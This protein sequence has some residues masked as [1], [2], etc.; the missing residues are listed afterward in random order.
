MKKTTLNITGMTCASCAKAV[1]R[2]GKKLSGVSESV[3]NF[4]TEELAVT[5]DEK[6]IKVQDIIAAINK[7]GYGAKEK[8]KDKSREEGKAKEQKNLVIRVIIS[9]VFTLPLLYISMGHMIGLPLPSFLLPDKKPILFAILQLILTVPVV[10]L[11]YKFY[12]IGFKSLF[13]LR[14]N[15]DSLIAVSTSSALIYGIFAII[16]IAKGDASYVHNL[17]FES[18]AVIITLV[19]L[20]KYLENKSKGRTSE[21]IKKLINLTPKTAVVIREGQETIVPF[22]DIKVGDILV[23][24]GGESL[25]VDGIVTEGYA[26]VDESMITGESMPVE[27]NIGDK[28][29]SASIISKGYIKYEAKKVGKDTTISQIIKLVEEAQGSKAP[30]SKL[31]DKISLYFVP[32]IMALAIISSLAWFISGESV[33]FAL[34]IF[35][36]VLVIACPCAL[37]LATPT[38]IMVGTGKGAE[39]GILIKNGEALETAHKIDTVVLDKTG[40][41]TE[42]NPKVTD[43]FAFNDYTNEQIIM[44]AASAEKGS[45]HPLGEAI[46]S[47]A[48]T[49]NIALSEVKNFNSETGF[50]ISAQILDKAVIIGNK[51]YMLKSGIALN[52]NEIVSEKLATEG[53]TPMYVAID[54]QLSGIVAVADV[55]KDNSKRAVE[56]LRKMNIDVVMLT[57]DNKETA[58]AIASSVGIDSTFAEVLPAEKA[59]KIKELK[60]SGKIVAMVGDGINDSP[61]LAMANVGIAIGS[62]TDIAI[63]SADIVLMKSDLL[64][65][66]TA[67]KLS[68]ST[69]KNI[70]ENL[71]WA[72]GY[73]IIGVPIAMGLLHL[74]NGPLLNPMIAGAAMSFSSVS[75][76]LNALRLTR[77]KKEH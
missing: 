10:V 52:D 37:G 20:G 30:I 55:V 60:D 11:G 49:Q 36:S 8:S 46:V 51:K 24:K 63:E 70:K 65:V 34:T 69:I 9:A 27:K 41:I 40:T 4:A 25:P 57:G 48:D 22:E 77:F 21:A 73:N 39:Y 19:S 1:E 62:G 38:A 56:L 68:K 23:V 42:G 47:Y 31:A 18:V 16:K 44:Y 33:T 14:P 67:I 17:Y 35:I 12:T 61:A 6:Q 7:S 74:F 54:S 5:Y 66:V 76:V 64:D 50:G 15:M 72:F 29:I 75:V 2:S 58:R 43:I 28:I 13:K 32:T 53:K 71:F 59:D 45:E 26:S 3:I